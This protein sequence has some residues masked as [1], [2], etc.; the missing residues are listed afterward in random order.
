MPTF[1]DFALDD[2]DALAGADALLRHLAGAGARL[3]VETATAQQ[4]LEVLGESLR[5][6]ALVASGPEARLIRAVLEPTCPVPMVAWPSH[7][8][9][10]WV[11]PLDVVVVLASIDHH[12]DAHNE[13]VLPTVH[14]AARRGCQVIVACPPTSPIVDHLSQRTTTIL[15]MV[16]GDPLAAAF[17]VL[18]ALHQMG[19]GPYVNVE[20]VADAVD[21]MSEM[22][23]PRVDVATNP[24]K[25]LALGFAELQ[26]LIWG[27]TTLAA[28]VSR[29]VA[30]AMRQWGGRAAIAA[31]ASDLLPI[32]HASRAHDPFADPFDGDEAELRPGLLIVDDGHEDDLDV[33]EHRQLL[34]A[35]E[36]RDIRV[37]TIEH[38][39]GSVFERYATTLQTGRYA[40]AYL[41]LGLGRLPGHG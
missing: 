13:K 4:S 35:A 15:P 5:P 12:E 28:R 19:L 33:V 36:E 20:Q 22:C 23:S 31:D 32:I 40:A 18:T 17:V 39:E 27:G 8:L 37:S 7:G 29:R 25:D 2:D 10:A 21:R 30:E 16:T 11:G 26:P 6:R 14:E 3:R 34:T 38:R 41:G 9:P 1:D 24:A